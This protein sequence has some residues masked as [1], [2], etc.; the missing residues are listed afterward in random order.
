[1][2]K[3]ITI[4]VL[5]VLAMSGF[6]Q[7]AHFDFSATS[8]TGYEIY[9]HI[10]DAENHCV[11]ATYPCQHDDN[12]WWGYDKPEGKLI[13]SETVN[14]DGVEYTLVAIGDHAFCSCTDLRGSLELPQTINLIGEG[15]FKGCSNLSG[16]LALPELITHVGEEAFANCS[17]LAGEL[18]FGDSLAYIGDRAFIQ[19]NFIGQLM[20]PSTLTFIGEEAFKGNTNIEGISIKAVAPPQTATNAFDD[21]PT[22]ISV[23]VPYLAQEPYQNSPGWSQFA[24]QIIEKS[25]WNGKAV[26]WTKGNGTNEDP[27]L[28]ESAENLAWLAKS[29]N[30]KLNID[31]LYDTT[32]YDVMAY[33]DTCFRLVIDIDLQKGRDFYWIPIGNIQYYAQ[34][35]YAG[36]NGFL[37]YFSG[38]FD[39]NGHEISNYLMH[40]NSSTEYIKYYF[41]LFGIIKDAFVGN[42]TVSHVEITSLNPYNTTGSITGYAIN[43]TISNCNAS[44]SLSIGSVELNQSGGIAGGIVGETQI[45]RIEHC[46]S[47]IEFVGYTSSVGGVVGQFLCDTNA[48]NTGIFHCGY[49]GAMTD[50]DCDAG[51]IVGKCNGLTEDKG[52]MRIENCFSR[53]SMTRFVLGQNWIENYNKG[54]GGIVGYAKSIDTLSIMNCYSN[55]TIIANTSNIHETDSYAGGIIAKADLST[56]LFIKNCYHVGPIESN[57]KGGIVGQNTNTTQIRNCYFDQAVAPD[58][59]FG[60][61]LDKEYMKTA[62]FVN[63]LN[64]GSTVFMM[65]HE[66]YANDGY[67]VFGTD[68][69]I[70]V[71]AEWY[72]EIT[73]NDGSI[74]YQH[75]VCT[76]DTIVQGKRP[77]VIV[78]SNTHYD[79]GEITEVTHEFVYE[80]NGIVY[81]WNNE[82]QEFT[83]LYDFSAEQGDRW[84]IKV[85][86]ERIVTTVYEIEIQMIDGIPYKKMTI[87]DDNNL[88]SGTLISTIGHLTYFFPEKLMNRGKGYRVEGM[89]CY[90]V[91]GELV[92]K[93]GDKDCDEVYEQLHHGIDEPGENG[94]STGSGALTVYP[95]PTDGV[96]FVETHGHASLSNQTYR[97][98]NLMG[99]TLLQ[100]RITDEIQKINIESLPAGMYFITFAGETLKFVIE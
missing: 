97:I 95:N 57:F 70:F 69:L 88:F 31:V 71:G 53:G 86:S 61:P 49:L 79:R 82:L 38:S 87:G 67:P 81:W 39:G 65:D 24:S 100:G 76:G 33:Q 92:F 99:Q 46:M 96:L 16:N 48:I 18:H 56:K 20:F 23:A 8:S 22:M 93:Y 10:I 85:G 83:V 68:G 60:V 58:E 28:I 45:C 89:R 73:N 29:V 12:Y 50:L 15:A 37:V 6:A 27:F 59:G 47:Q 51:G 2:K 35:N 77:K 55:D 36:N 3:I 5:M 4:A 66:P 17:R 41:G 19:C 26:P 62:A 98:T 94:P 42:T 54:F 40:T 7:E 72:Y 52:N 43:S 78:R 1:M 64:N 75:L 84:E 11:E 9:Y 34:P 14:H 91:N 13:L 21:V 32:Y 63:Q 74:T 44:G 90:W 80:E 25:Y 30:E